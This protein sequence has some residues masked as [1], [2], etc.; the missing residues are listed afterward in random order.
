MALLVIR[1]R[2]PTCQ[3]AVKKDDVV[4]LESATGAGLALLHRLYSGMKD[5]GWWVMTMTEHGKGAEKWPW[6][7]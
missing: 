4:K 7:F 1:V 6:T 3:Q 5:G 2:G